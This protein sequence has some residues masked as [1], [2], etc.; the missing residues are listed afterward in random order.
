MTGKRL[1]VGKRQQFV[2]PILLS[3]GGSYGTIR[4]CQEEK[5][6][7]RVI[8]TR[9]TVADPRPRRSLGT[10]AAGTVI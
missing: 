10:M 8:G 4:R 5:Y 9:L 3:N 2:D 6:P 7:G 1:Q